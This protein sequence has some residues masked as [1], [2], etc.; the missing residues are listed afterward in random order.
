MGSR[1]DSPSAELYGAGISPILTT[2]GY[3]PRFSVIRTG[4]K[5]S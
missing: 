3:L 1:T 5:A 2:G 4:H